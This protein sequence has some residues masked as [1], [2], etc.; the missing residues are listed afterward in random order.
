MLQWLAQF[1]P[2]WVANFALSLLAVLW[3]TLMR[4]G[5]VATKRG[6][7]ITLRKIA[8]EVPTLFSMAIIAGPG[9]VYLRDTYHVDESATYALCVF[10]GYLGA[11][12]LDRVAAYWE[13]KDEKE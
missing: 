2:D 1:V 9:G 5:H 7:R 12:I 6:E 10:L 11:N 3:G 13:K 4:L 8:L